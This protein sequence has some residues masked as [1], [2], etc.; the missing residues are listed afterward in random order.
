M[1]TDQFTHLQFVYL[2]S[3]FRLRKQ[4]QNFIHIVISAVHTSLW[5]NSDLTE[6]QEKGI[7]ILQAENTTPSP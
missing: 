2:Y 6:S 4:Q 7:A 3:I 1:D 5:F